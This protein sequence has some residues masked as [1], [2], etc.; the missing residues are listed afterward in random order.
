G[1]PLGPNDLE[2]A[3]TKAFDYWRY[4]DNQQ[5][6]L[7][8]EGQ[9]KAAARLGLLVSFAYR[10]VACIEK[11]MDLK[12]QAGSVD[13][14]L[15]AFQSEYNRIK[16]REFIRFEETIRSRQWP[17]LQPYPQR[18]LPITREHILVTYFDDIL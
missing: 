5:W 9:H 15:M 18:V 16:D 10:T 11:M 14:Y 3:H 17:L 1:Y 6:A 12:K 13:Q 4:L 8:A 2:R 7:D